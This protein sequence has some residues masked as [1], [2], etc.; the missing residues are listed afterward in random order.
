MVRTSTAQEDRFIDQKHRATFVRLLVQNGDNIAV[1]VCDLYGK[2]WLISAEYGDGVDEQSQNATFTLKRDYFDL[3]LARENQTSRANLL[4]NGNYNPL[5][6]IGRYV[7]LQV[8]VGPHRDR[9]VSAETAWRSVFIGKIDRVDDSSDPITIECRDYLSAECMDR[10]IEV[11]DNTQNVY[12]TTPTGTPVEDVM[13]DIVDDWTTPGLVDIWAPTS[14]SWDILQYAA[15][16]APVMD[17]LMKLAAQIGWVVRPRWD[18]S[19][20]RFRLAL[21]D[22]DRTKTV[23]DVTIP[24]GNIIAARRHEVQLDNIRNVIQVAYGG[25]R[26]PVGTQ[27]TDIDPTSGRRWVTSTDSA[28]V[29]AYGRRFMYVAE[30]SSSNITTMAEAQR[31]ADAIRDDLST[32]IVEYSVEVPFDWRIELT[33]LVRVPA[34]GRIHTSAVDLAVIRVTHSLGLDGCTTTLELRGSPAAYHLTHIDD[35]QA[36]PGG[37]P[38]RDQTE[39]NAPTPTFTSGLAGAHI[40]VP[41]ELGPRTDRVWDQFEVHTSTTNGFTPSIATL[42]ARIRAPV[43]KFE[44]APGETYYSRVVALTKEGVRSDPSAQVSAQAGYAGPQLLD[45]GIDFGFLPGRGFDVAMRGAS[46][47]PDGWTMVAGAW[48][49]DASRITSPVESGDYSIQFDNPA[50]TIASRYMPVQRNYPYKAAVRLQADANSPGDS[51]TITLEFHSNQGTVVS[52][53]SVASADEVSAINTWETWSN[54][55]TSPSTARWCRIVIT[56]DS[57]SNATL[58][59]NRV[60]V[61]RMLHSGRAYLSGTHTFSANNTWEQLQ[62]DTEVFDLG[63]W[64]DTSSFYFQAPEDG[65]YEFGAGAAFENCDLDIGLSIYV[66]SSPVATITADSASTA[67]DAVGNLTLLTG[68]IMLVAGDRVD[69][70]ARGDASSGT[71]EVGP[72]AAETFFWGRRTA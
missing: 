39:L 4:A 52:S 17:E 12:S 46:Y 58:V 65:M 33:D 44:G 27:F 18:D 66:E 36:R 61:E 23:P 59:V 25:P 10:W 45:P 21:I 63:A 11:E 68:P 28:S 3:S 7:T 22:P 57:G 48:G 15:D 69:L 47:P 24:S 70:Y 43:Y 5:L 6:E 26:T 31:M 49:T 53:L 72:G 67:G 1:N 64:F 34:D 16:S 37:A 71:G 13:Q 20:E 2:N 62:I 8:A 55:G 29:A 35:R 19:A 9:A 50:T 60:E 30:G 32:P 41:F 42:S 56:S 14:P 51:F 38:G 54:F 40:D